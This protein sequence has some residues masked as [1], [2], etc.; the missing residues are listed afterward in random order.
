MIEH[1]DLSIHPGSPM[2]RSTPSALAFTTELHNPATG[3]TR[4]T[5]VRLEIDAGRLVLWWT[6]HTFGKPFAGPPPPHMEV[7]QDGVARLQISYA[8]KDAPGAWL[9]SWHRPGLPGLVR[10]DMQSANGAKA[11][12]PIIVGPPREP[13]ER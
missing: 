5:D 7:L 12:P 6:P 10:L 9:S 13:A 2:L 3:G 4:T 11:W 8:A 1:I